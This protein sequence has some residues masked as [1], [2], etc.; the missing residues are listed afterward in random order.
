MNDKITLFFA[1]K[2]GCPSKRLTVDRYASILK[3]GSTLLAR[4]SPVGFLADHNT[5][6]DNTTIII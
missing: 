2:K 1:S 6:I 3:V 5:I 4:Y